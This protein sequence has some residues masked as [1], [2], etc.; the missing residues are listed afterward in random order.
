[1]LA[2]TVGIVAHAGLGI[3]LAVVV[4]AIGLGCVRGLRDGNAL[5]YAFGLLVLSIAALLVV[6]SPWLSPVALVL[7]CAPL[8]RLK[9]LGGVLRRVARPFA[10]SFPAALGLGLALGLLNHG[11]TREEDS[12]AFGDMLFYAAKA[13]AATESL[14]PFHDLTVEGESHGWLET[15]WT[16]LT[17]A[18]SWL[19]G[20]DVVLLQ[21]ATA[22]AF[23]VAA[24]TIGVGLVPPNDR[25][26]GWVPVAAVLAVSLVAYPTWLTESPP[27]ALAVPLA[28]PAYALW[29]RPLPIGWF[30]ASIAVIG[31][32][33]FLTKGFGV[34]PLAV[35]TTVVLVRDHGRRAAVSALAAAAVVVA[36]V[37]ILF[38]LT[39]AW[40]TDLLGLKFVPADAARGL[41]RQLDVRDTQAAAPALLVAGQVLLAVALVRARAFT[42]TA[43]LGA[44]LIGSWIVSGHG[45]DITVGI[46]VLLAALLFLEFPS[47]LE[48]HRVLVV[49][50]AVS[51]TLSAWFRETAGVH[52]GFLLV[53]LLAAGLLAAFA[54]SPRPLA[55]AAAAVAVG[56][57]LGLGE[58]Q[59]T[60]TPSDYTLWRHVARTVA[61]DALVF[62]SETGPEIT[63][64][65]GWN[66]YPGLAGRQVY[67]AGWSNSSLVV[68]G[69]E[70]AQR[71][72]LNRDVLSGRLSPV[73]LRLSRDYGAYYAVLLRD[74]RAPR[75]FRRVY[76]NERFALYRIPS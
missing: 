66:Y 72:R 22:P 8:I 43:A 61:E 25:R 41:W 56:L 18:L 46:A 2:L 33:L 50:A 44:S 59:T 32:D 60:L 10:W 7:V 38:A 65:Q 5:A 48:R 70:R 27:V 29:R 42:F 74:E 57:L 3:A 76:R 73:D 51:L 12:T 16:F 15:G 35:V 49:S 28:F 11:P 64:T 34:I 40:L 24:V 68:D 13:V 36:A 45:F 9:G 21:A 63:G 31:V 23:L 58:R 4:W 71:L 69:A 55:A 62:T 47:L 26:S 30:A 37:A 14:F 1:V 67:L 17:A 39:S 54:P 6:A 75:S 53:A 52:A 20:V 19:P